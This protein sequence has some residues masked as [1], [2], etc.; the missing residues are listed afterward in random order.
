MFMHLKVNACMKKRTPQEKKELSYK[1][2]RRNVYGEAPHAARKGIPL[3]KALRNRANRHVANQAVDYQGP[4]P[5]EDLADE[6][7]SRLHYRATNEWKKHRDAPLGEVIA[8]KSRNRKTMREHGGREALIIRYAPKKTTTD[9]QS[10]FFTSQSE[11]RRWLEKNHAKEK[12]LLVGFYKKA[13]GK[14]SITYPE[15]LDEALCF[16]WIDGVR[17]RFSDD[18]YVQRFTP[19]KA[20]S[21]WSNVNVRHVERLKKLGRMRP[22]GLEAYAL[23]D[24]K[25]T[26]IYAYENRPREFSP[27]Y[28]KKFRANKKAWEFFEKEPPSIRRVCIFWV[29]SAKQEETRQRRLDQLIESSAKGERR[30]VITTKSKK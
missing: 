19:R 27:A 26:G 5:N 29:M 6:L 11:F 10:R 12:E 17:K 30:G 14:P 18:A 28:E 2:D 25:K 1:R 22:S 9:D 7:E 23:R 21:I 20:K 4:A 24:L 15:A 8:N 16:G 13:S 3:R